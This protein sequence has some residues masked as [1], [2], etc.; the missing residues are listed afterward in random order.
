MV[1]Y[2]LAKEGGKS[3]KLEANPRWKGGDAGYYSIHQCLTRNH[4]KPPSCAHCRCKGHEE[5]DGRWSIQWAKRKYKRYTRNVN[6][7]L[8]LCRSCHRKYDMTDKERERLA[9]M[10]QN[11]SVEKR[12]KMS[13]SQKKVV[14]KR[15][16][17]KHGKFTKAA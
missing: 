8:R 12:V 11:Q 7:Y 5:K 13:V 17:N 1:D 3:Q 10:A 6:D 9:V 15:K 16:R 2:K 14:S 4:G